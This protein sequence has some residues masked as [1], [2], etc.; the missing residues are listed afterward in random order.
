MSFEHRASSTDRRNL[1]DF[2]EAIAR[3]E[4]ADE[5]MAF[6]TRG[7]HRM[8][9]G[10]FTAWNEFEVGPFR[11]SRFF[12]VPAVGDVA[13]S[14][15]EPLMACL[16]DHPSF[17]A[18]E[19]GR[20]IAP[21]F[22]LSDHMP[23]SRFRETGLFREVYRHLES[24]F[25]II[26]GMPAPPGILRIITINRWHSDFGSR[27]RALLAQVESPL[28]QA[29]RRTH[30]G[31]D[32]EYQLRAH[33]TA[34]HT[35]ATLRLD[36]SLNL[37]EA[38]PEALRTLQAYSES[39]GASDSGL[40]ASLVTWIE[41]ELTADPVEKDERLWRQ[42]GISQTVMTRGRDHLVVSLDRAGDEIRLHLRVSNSLRARVHPAWET[43]TPRKEEILRW[44]AEGKTNDEIALILGIS[45]K[46]VE[47]HLSDLCRVFGVNN[48]IGLV[49]EFFCR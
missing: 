12:L 39:N 20:W 40:P 37:L 24:R 6:A 5:L 8:L 2:T 43:L 7:L 17:P 21:I 26:L 23:F 3:F 35:G 14:L 19:T 22:H 42:R 10:D 29:V 13:F 38:S 28:A 47:K 25:Q 45:A 32:F 49:R 16:P 46:G 11:P 36:P 27:E 31:Y 4:D 44:V 48:R 34:G 15:T 18:F 1:R 41:N 30:L 9:G 33:M